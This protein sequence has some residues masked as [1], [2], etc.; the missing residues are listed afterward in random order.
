MFIHITNQ[1][2]PS[3][4]RR[5]LRSP[6]SQAWP[7][8]RL[9]KNRGRAYVVVML[10]ILVYPTERAVSQPI[11]EVCFFWELLGDASDGVIDLDAGEDTAKL[12]LWADMRPDVNGVDVMGYAGS[13]FDMLGSGISGAGELFMT[14]PEGDGSAGINE[15]LDDLSVDYTIDPNT[16]SFLRVETYQLPPAFNP[17]FDANDPIFIAEFDWISDG[18]LG[19][20]TYE[21]A[22][23]VDDASVYFSALGGSQV[24]DVSC[25]EGV[26][27]DVVPSPSTLALLGMGMMAMARHRRCD[28]SM[29][30]AH[31]RA[32]ST[33]D[34]SVPTACNLWI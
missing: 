21:V 8:T 4:L 10:G 9:T 31:A 15:R 2:V 27:F 30:R 3:F 14:D 29:R 11:G 13:I 23:W 22:N 32:P 1:E 16:N 5:I 24:W 18:T 17:N 20:V 6:G 25:S 19:T 12:R 7:A 33:S 34:S 28:R 26:R